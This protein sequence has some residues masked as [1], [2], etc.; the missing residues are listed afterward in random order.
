M[1][2]RKKSGEDVNGESWLMITLWDT[3]APASEP[4]KIE[5]NGLRGLVE[6]ALRAEGLRKR[7]DMKRVR[8][9][10]FKANHGFCK[11]FQT[12]AEPKMKSL[13]VMTL[14]G[15]DTGLA[16]SYNKPT[17]HMLL[18]EYLKAVDN[19]T[20]DKSRISQSVV[21]KV[22][23]NQQ[24][25]VAEMHAKD[26]EIHELK[27]QVEEIRDLYQGLVKTLNEA[28]DLREKVRAN[29]QEF[30]EA[31][32]FKFVAMQKRRHKDA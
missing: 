26:Q 10:E 14:M 2:F 8:H 21:E 4:I 27:E 22:S 3:N 9:H 5:T 30:L 25:L 32:P 18:E 17:V 7:L 11:F 13:D 15:Q 24:V 12:N 1:D 28:V 23:E 31:D 29:P 6:R 20:I 16:A 19:L